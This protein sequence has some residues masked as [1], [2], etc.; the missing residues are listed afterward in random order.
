MQHMAEDATRQAIQTAAEHARAGL[1]LAS[2][3]R[4]AEAV[5]HLSRWAALQPQSFEAHYNF[6]RA[7]RDLRQHEHAAAEFRAAVRLNP[8]FAPAWNN[9]GNT[10]RDLAALDEAMECYDKALELRPN[11]APT[12]HNL[13]LLFQDRLQTTDAMRAFDKA[14][15]LKSDY[16]EAL[17][18]RA[19]LQLLLGDYENGWRGY[20][21][22][23]AVP[24]A[25]PPRGF[26]QPFWDGSDLKGKTVLLHAEQGFGDTIQFCRYAPLVAQRG[27]EPIVECQP[28]LRTLLGALPGVRQV[29]ARGEPLPPFDLHCPL[30][31]LPLRFG[32]TVVTI[33]ASVPYLS[34]DGG[35]IAQW[36]EKLAVERAFRIGIVWS[37][38]AGYGNDRRRS[39]HLSMLASLARIESVQWYSL[40]KGDA[41]RQAEHAP[42]G[43]RLI[44]LTAD[45]H[46]FADTAALITHLDLVICVDT[47]VAHLAGAMGK[48]VWTLLPLSPDWRWMLGREESPWYPTMRLYRQPAWGDWASVI[49]QVAGDLCRHI[50]SLS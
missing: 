31:G 45:L 26:S 4:V 1:F 5:V 7:L 17:A 16:A 48:A 43:M 15:E 27:A 23:W 42:H 49:E 34:A 6:G 24:Q 38:A 25:L 10:L 33:P 20:E 46:D 11:H 30:L 28:E 29:M 9:L 14:I 37:G 36:R 39:L 18:G 44:D 22:R 41:A 47:A 21:A 19:M 13:A 2:Q 12:Y 35:R 32:T 40:Q 3:G 50:R 8:A